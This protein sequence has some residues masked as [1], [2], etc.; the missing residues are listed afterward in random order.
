[1]YLFC[2][3]QTITMATTASSKQNRPAAAATRGITNE[4]SSPSPP[5]WFVLSGPDV[6]GED[7][8][9]WGDVVVEVLL[10]WYPDVV[11]DVVADVVDDVIYDV[12]G[13]GDDVSITWGIYKIFFEH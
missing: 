11:G 10:F 2:R 1:M 3:L 5:S 8:R 12:V 13:V 4:D 9:G 7:G 6:S